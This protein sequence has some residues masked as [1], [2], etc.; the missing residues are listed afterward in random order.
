ME[1]DRIKSK[2]KTQ[3]KSFENKIKFKRMKTYNFATIIIA[4]VCIS[5]CVS[6]KP[7]VTSTNEAIDNYKY[8]YITP[9]SNLT[10]SSGS[11][12]GGQYYSTSKTVNPSDIIAGLL[13]KEKFI[14]LPEL[15]AELADETLI[16]NYGESGRRMVGLGG[17]TIEVTIS[18][19]SAKTYQEICSCTAEGIGTTEADDI[20]NAIT[21]CL[22]S[23]F[24]K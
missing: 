15:Q 2:D 18:F 7:P 6:L 12:Y 11:T 4:S 13:L 1:S 21:R 10:S 16:V 14:R 20:R 19:I 23:L 3:E 22:N 5:S 17:Y 24:A 9:T 8:I